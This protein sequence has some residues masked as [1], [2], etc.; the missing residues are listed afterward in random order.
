MLLEVWN[1]KKTSNTEHSIWGSF[2]QSLPN[3]RFHNHKFTCFWIRGFVVGT[4][5]KDHLRDIF[6]GG[7]KKKI[8]QSSYLCNIHTY[9]FGLQNSEEEKNEAIF[10]YNMFQHFRQLNLTLIL[11]GSYWLKIRIYIKAHIKFWNE[12]NWWCLK[13]TQKCVHTK[14]QQACGE[15]KLM[16]RETKL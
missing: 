3:Q 9:D 5:T 16:C 12:K 1:K 13:Q 10:M 7:K 4:K 6:G 14:M 2:C 8:N 11:S 15:N